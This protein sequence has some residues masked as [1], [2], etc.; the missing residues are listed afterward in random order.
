MSGYFRAKSNYDTKARETTSANAGT[1]NFYSTIAAHGRSSFGFTRLPDAHG[2]GLLYYTIWVYYR[3]VLDIAQE[4]KKP[5][6]SNKLSFSPLAK[7]AILL[8][9]FY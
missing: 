9:D 3:V 6:F 7:A 1:G 8:S 4:R 2:Q 5:K